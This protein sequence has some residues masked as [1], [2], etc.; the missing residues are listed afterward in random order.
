MKLE[1]SNNYKVCTDDSCSKLQ[2][3]ASL[4][5]KKSSSLTFKIERTFGINNILKSYNSKKNL[6]GRRTNSCI[7]YKE[8]SQPQNRHISI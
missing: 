3:T 2:G 4:E 1:S 7:T 6:S 5:P 8:Y